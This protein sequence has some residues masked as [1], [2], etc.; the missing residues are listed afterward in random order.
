MLQA[1]RNSVLTYGTQSLVTYF[2]TLILAACAGQSLIA[3]LAKFEKDI[4]TI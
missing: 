1:G 2:V 4:R 3:H